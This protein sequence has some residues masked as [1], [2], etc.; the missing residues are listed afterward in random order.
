MDK[1]TR[2]RIEDLV[3]TLQTRAQ[4]LGAIEAD[5]P[6]SDA[7]QQEASAIG[8]VALDM[9][10]WLDEERRREKRESRMSLLRGVLAFLVLAGVLAVNVYVFREN[11]LAQDGDYLKAI[12]QFF[13]EMADQATW[14]EYLKLAVAGC[15][16][17]M[18]FL[19]SLIAAMFLEVFLKA[20]RVPMNALVFS[21]LAAGLS[22]VVLY[23]YIS[24]FGFLRETLYRFV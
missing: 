2:M 9:E 3:E 6:V 1:K 4:A 12:R 21:M 13:P 8:G 11:S 22:A 18:S 14:A 16:G 19:L 17:L 24:N 23:Y 7:V 5:P 20:V 10:E 15:L